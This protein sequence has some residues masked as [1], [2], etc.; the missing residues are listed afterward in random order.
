[1]NMIKRIIRLFAVIALLLLPIGAFSA[2]IP[3]LRFIAPIYADSKGGALK[4]PEGVACNYK[5]LVVVADTGKNRLIKYT[6]VDGAL[7]GGDELSVSG[8][9]NPLRVQVNSKG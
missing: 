1:M 2:D 3:K 5:S 6:F 4:Q 9:S 8:L 7:Q